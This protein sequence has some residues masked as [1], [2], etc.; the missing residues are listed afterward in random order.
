M[1]S[2]PLEVFMMQLDNV[3]S[4]LTWIQCWSLS[5]SRILDWRLSKSLPARSTVDAC[6][7][8]DWRWRLAILVSE[9]GTKHFSCHTIWWKGLS[10][11]AA[12]FLPLP[13]LLCL[14]P[15]CRAFFHL[16]LV[17]CLSK[18]DPRYYMAVMCHRYEIA[19]TWCWAV[20]NRSQCNGMLDFWH[21]DTQ[22]GF[23]WPWI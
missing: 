8:L 19:R 11:A 13:P 20:S 21:W 14:S 23:K 10:P 2:Q 16:L 12:Q 9:A 15:L 6:G 5:W 7:N 1:P 22:N 3:L 4:N 18:G 17:F